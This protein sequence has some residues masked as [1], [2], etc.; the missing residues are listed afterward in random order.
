M[1]VCAVCPRLARTG[2][3]AFLVLP[4]LSTMTLYPRSGLLRDPAETPPCSVQL[5]FVQNGVATCLRAR[6]HS[7]NALDFVE[8][9]AE[10]L[11]HD[12]VHGEVSRR[13]GLIDPL[14]CL[15]IACSPGSDEMDQIRKESKSG[16]RTFPTPSYA[17]A[18]IILACR[19]R[20]RDT[21]QSRSATSRAQI[22]TKIS[23]GFMAPT[24]RAN[25][26]S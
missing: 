16:S 19:R 18:V 1:G 7:R 13:E 17:V 23:S 3:A 14:D 24:I 15:F 10:S 11:G 6:N 26:S 25:R 9:G 21:S 2:H 5:N 4:D 22:S 8:I 20:K 12:S